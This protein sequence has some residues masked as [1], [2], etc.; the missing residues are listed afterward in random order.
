MSDRNYEYKTLQGDTFDS[1]A[2]DFYGEEYKAGLL[3]EANP[4]HIRT[5]RFDGGVVLKVPIIEAEQA[6]TLPPWKQEG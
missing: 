3:M 2:L 5:L 1:I 6:A 4:D